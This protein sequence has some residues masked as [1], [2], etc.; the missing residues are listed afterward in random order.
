M[1]D[2]TGRLRETSDTLLRELDVLRTLEEEKR[3]VAIGSPRFRDLAEEIESLSAKVLELSRRQ[4]DLGEA[5]EGRPSVE[6]ATTVNEAPRELWRIL[7]EWR[8]AER[9]AITAP[10]GS[11]ESEAATVEAE[12]LRTE[13]RTSYAR[14]ESPDQA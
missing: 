5:V 4:L 3:S 13:Y 11:A 9:R 6:G 12:R 1:T 2:S 7:A 14:R 10:P 8:E